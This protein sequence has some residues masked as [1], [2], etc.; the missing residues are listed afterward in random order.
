TS[1]KRDWS[2]DVC[3]SDL[4]SYFGA[5]FNP[6]RRHPAHRDIH[7]ASAITAGKNDDHY[8]FPRCDGLAAVILGDAGKILQGLK[9]CALEA[10]GQ[11][12]S[13]WGREM[14]WIKVE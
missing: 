7:L 14:V 10:S 13:A 2:S 6:D 5:Q 1:S 9:R 4:Q 12:G 3:S 11:I 8:Q